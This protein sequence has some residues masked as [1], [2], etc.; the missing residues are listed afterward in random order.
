MVLL[1]SINRSVSKLGESAKRRTV[2][3][4]VAQRLGVI[5]THVKPPSNERYTPPLP[6]ANTR[7]S[8]ATVGDG[9]S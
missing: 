7:L 3:R 8:R 2:A 6:E 9:V 5:K 4:G 1:N